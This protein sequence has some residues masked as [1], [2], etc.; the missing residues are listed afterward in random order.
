MYIRIVKEVGSMEFKI[1]KTNFLISEFEE[2]EKWLTTMHSQGWKLIEISHNNYKFEKCQPGDWVYQLDFQNKMIEESNYIKL[3]G[4]YG[5]N[6]VLKHNNWFYFRRIKNVKDCN[7]DLS[8]FSDKDSKITMCQ[9]ALSGKL[10]INVSLFFIACII[11]VLSI[12]TNTFSS[13]STVLIPNFTWLNN[14][15]KA[16]LPWIGMGLMVATSFSFSDYNKI[17]NKINMMKQPLG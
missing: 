3:F 16:V 5:W 6:F 15:L 7:T 13:A 4:D 2:E 11:L 10:K 1:I 17:R 14:F 9:R 8:I 12:F